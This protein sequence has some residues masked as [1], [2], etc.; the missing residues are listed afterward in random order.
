MA[1]RCHYAV[2]T[3]SATRSR[4]SS[5]R[6][7]PARRRVLEESGHEAA[8]RIKLLEEASEAQAAP[9]GKLLPELA[10]VLKVILALA[11]LMT[12]AGKTRR[13]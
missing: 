7:V 5:G 3:S 11:R 8:L 4:G 9:D 12:W 6:R 2:S 13:W 1:T 10:D